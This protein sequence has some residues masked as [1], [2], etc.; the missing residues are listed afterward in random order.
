MEKL[1][2]LVVAM[3]MITTV[4]FALETAEDEVLAE[5]RAQSGVSGQIFADLIFDDLTTED[6]IIKWDSLSIEE[7]T[8][9]KTDLRSNVM[10]MSSDERMSFR[11]EMHTRVSSLST[12]DRQQFFE[13]RRAAFEAMP[14]A[15]R[16][17]M[18]E[19]RRAA[20]EAMSDEEKDAM[21]ANRPSFGKG[22]GMGRGGMGRGMW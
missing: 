20:F 6:A 1:I 8:Q 13:E 11:E 4:G 19:D 18:R 21:R 2:A 7:Q 22:G 15:E 5:I 17:Q 14:V 16:D 12:E 10:N 3:V 9:A